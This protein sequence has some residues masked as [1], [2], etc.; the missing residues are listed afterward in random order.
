MEYQQ[1]G[2]SQLHISR[3]GFGCMS[4]KPGQSDFFQLV[5]SAVDAGINHFDTADLYDKGMNE[6]QIGAVLK[7]FR[8][9]VILATKAGNQWL[10]DGQSWTWN[11]SKEYI[12]QCA[13]ASLKRLQ[14]DYIAVSYTH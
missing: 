7:P 12:L 3:I 14:T 6:E 5:E 2:G 11:P 8:N 9:K 13:D 4:L 10:P 1:L